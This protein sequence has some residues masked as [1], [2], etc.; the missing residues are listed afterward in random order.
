MCSSQSPDHVTVVLRKPVRGKTGP[1]TV[2][3]EA[4]GRDTF[5]RV[6]E[7][8]QYM[9]LIMDP[10]QIGP[11]WLDVVWMDCDH[12]KGTVVRIVNTVHEVMRCTV[13]DLAGTTMA[14]YDVPPSGG[15]LLTEGN[16]WFETGAKITIRRLSVRRENNARV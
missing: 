11:C 9:C 8:E 7:S 13:K 10:H 2:V 15:M 3:L 12:A 6:P 4:P 1:S 5:W 14:R 16:P